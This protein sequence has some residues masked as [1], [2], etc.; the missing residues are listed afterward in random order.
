MSLAINLS[1]LTVATPEKLV[2]HAGVA[3]RNANLEELEATGGG[4]ADA[5]NPENT[6]T[7]NG[8]TFTPQPYGAT[9]EGFTIDPGLPINPI[10]GIDGALGATVG[11]LEV[12][13]FNPSIAGQLLE[14]N[15]YR[16][17]KEALGAADATLTDSGL[18]KIEPRSYVTA[19]DHLGNITIFCQ[20]SNSTISQFW[21]VV[22]LNPIALPQSHQL[23]RGA[24]VLPIKY[25]GCADLEASGKP[26]I[27]YYVPHVAG[28]GSGS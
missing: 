7:K 14:M 28:E 9:K 5:V 11:L 4:F 21:V 15:D 16:K 23:K 6:W 3:Y 10:D 20:T 22:L 26:P 24:N 19:N 13:G 25:I 18:W 17:M 2:V 8:R 1:A 12:T 27:R